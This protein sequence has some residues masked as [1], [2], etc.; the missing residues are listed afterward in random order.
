MTSVN[1]AH[2][3]LSSPTTSE[4]Q[5]NVRDAA[6]CG[7]SLAFSKPVVKPKPLLN[8][9]T[10]GSNG[11]LVAATKVSSP[12]LRPS[13]PKGSGSPIGRDYT[14]VSFRPSPSPLQYSSKS[15]SSSALEVP[16]NSVHPT[17]SPSNIA[18]KLA[19]ARFSPMRPRLNTAS[20]MMYAQPNKEERDILPP[21]G[22]VGNAMARLNLSD[23]GLVKRPKSRDGESPRTIKQRDGTSEAEATDGAPIP[24]TNSLVSMF[25][26]NRPKMPTRR[27]TPVQTPHEAL[28]PVQSPKPQRK[29]CISL[30]PP[31]EG[32][33]EKPQDGVPAKPPV[34]QKPRALAPLSEPQV[35][36][37]REPNTAR[38]GS[39]PVPPAKP[40]QLARLKTP[41]TPPKPPVRRGSRPPSRDL[42]R[43]PSLLLQLSR[44][45]DSNEVLSS[46][47]SYAS[48]PETQEEKPRPEPPPPRRS[49]KKNVSESTRKPQTKLM[50]GLPVPRRLESP[51]KTSSVP[52][53]PRSPMDTSSV[54]P[55]LM[56]P[57]KTSSVPP[58]P[59]PPTETSSL[60]VFP[61]HFDPRRPSTATSTTSQSDSIYHNNYQR[62][63]VQRVAQHLTGDGLSNAIVGAA[64]ASSRRPSPHPLTTDVPPLP[65][66]RKE[67]HHHPHLS[68]HHNRSPSPS[69]SKPEPGKL[70]STLRKEDSSSSE[71]EFERYKRKGSRVLGLRKKH[72]N[73]HHE[74]TRKR[75]R[76]TVTERERKRYEGVWAANKGLYISS[77]PT[78]SR[79]QSSSA[80]TS[81]SPRLSPSN[82]PSESEDVLNLLVCEIWSRSRLP[83]HT[84]EEVWDLVDSRGVGKLRRDEFV[85][86]MWLIDQL[87]KGRKLPVR[88]TE[89]VWGSVRGAGVG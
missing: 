32:T 72:P 2:T 56:S 49:T 42:V 40:P 76:D 1:H 52:P 44:S 81:A 58:K 23:K 21:A 73:K 30:E 34:K 61:E 37:T 87:L 46:P 9:Y 6:L 25:E 80:A 41:L 88:V 70:K 65:P 24:P 5:Y 68:F 55:R 12:N 89:S 84:L 67:H 77:S 71:D 79:P 8:T 43:S 59:K 45:V 29:L 75:W 60:T 62:Q 22:S 15:S 47:S 48:A 4:T 57:I 35:M 31:M 36:G 20:S 38:K 85:V 69:K 26:Q 19:A 11:A 63:S 10:G 64:L 14:G 50:Y 54:P 16:G 13:T 51:I 78:P 74:G 86:G 18:A 3:P 27:Q 33:R 82:L 66:P 28:L 53:K 7:A 17:P 39:F 83:E